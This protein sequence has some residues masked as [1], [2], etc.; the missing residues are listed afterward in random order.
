MS[1]CEHLQNAL[2]GSRPQHSQQRQII[3]YS[4]LLALYLRISTASNG[5]CCS[6]ADA[7]SCSR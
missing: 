7:S 4:C 5:S 2:P 1:H 6:M 3:Y